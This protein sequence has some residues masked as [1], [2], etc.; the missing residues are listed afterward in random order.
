VGRAERGRGAGGRGLAGDGGC[1]R[2]GSF[3]LEKARSG[4]EGQPRGVDGPGAQGGPDRAPL[5]S[6]ANC[7]EELIKHGL[8]DSVLGNTPQ[9][10]PAPTPFWSLGLSERLSTRATC[11]AHLGQAQLL[12]PLKIY[13]NERSEMKA[14]WTLSPADLTNAHN[15]CAKLFFASTMSPRDLDEGR[16]RNVVRAAFCDLPMRCLCCA[17]VITM[18]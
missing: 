8:R 15:R 2:A 6:G 3:A 7:A 13:T 18:Y 1:A 4:C 16:P 17:S 10:H 12:G 14:F 5:E 9:V 11:Q